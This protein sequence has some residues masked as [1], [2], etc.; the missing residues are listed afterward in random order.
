MGR[1]SVVEREELWD[2]WE[3]GE[4]QRSICRRLGRSPST[5]RTHLSSSGWRRPTETGEWCSLRLSLGERGEISRGLACHESLRFFA[6]RLGRSPSRVSREVK[7]NGG[8]GRYRATVA[9]LASRSR[10]IRPRAMTLQ[11]C[12]RLCVAIEAKLELWWSPAQVSRWLIRA[13]PHDEEMRV[14]HDDPL[15]RP[16]RPQFPPLHGTHTSG[17]YG[18]TSPMGS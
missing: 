14:S 9:H 10:A 15:K 8:H 3:A 11:E 12:R 4:S 7:I 2:R 16:T 13:Y 17:T 5:V 18:Q 1:L 6:H